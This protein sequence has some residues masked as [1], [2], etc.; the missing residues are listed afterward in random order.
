MDQIRV[1]EPR[2]AERAGRKVPL[3][4]A[5]FRIRRDEVLSMSCEVD[6]I[7]PDTW[8]IRFSRTFIGK[9]GVEN[10]EPYLAA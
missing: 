1:G 6:Y 2:G 10:G 3:A 4:E 7:V 5:H 9:A 8:P